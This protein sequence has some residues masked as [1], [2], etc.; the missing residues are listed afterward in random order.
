MKFLNFRKNSNNLSVVFII[1]RP[2]S[3]TSA[4]RDILRQ[5]PSAAILPE[6]FHNDYLDNDNFF[7][8]FFLKQ[9]S[10]D[11][12]LALPSPENREKL[13]LDYI[14]YLEHRYSKGKHKKRILSVTV[15]YNSLHCLN[16]YWQNSH[17]VPYLFLLIEKFHFKVIHLVR[18]NI[19]AALISEERARQ[20]GVWHLTKDGANDTRPPKARIN[21]TT[22]VNELSERQ[23]EIRMLDEFLAR[24]MPDRRL[25]VTYESLF[26]IGTNLPSAEILEKIRLFVGIDEVLAPETRFLRTAARSFSESVEN[27]G[28]VAN[29][30]ASTEYSR[31]IQ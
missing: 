8:N 6:I 24:R 29:T 18:E 10:K 19:L 27:F 23:R 4:L 21:T 28:D 5:A 13:L 17:D 9:I 2:R 26:P 1:A 11:I 7:F 22:L 12:K 25:L 3:G 30:L 31:F 16:T 15:N 14:A 20:S